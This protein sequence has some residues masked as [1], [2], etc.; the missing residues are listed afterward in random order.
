MADSFDSSELQQIK[1]DIMSTAID[2]GVTFFD[3]VG[4]IDR[5]AKDVTNYSLIPIE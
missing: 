5:I 3:C 2:R 1:M 4:A